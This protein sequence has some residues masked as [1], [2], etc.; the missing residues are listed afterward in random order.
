MIKIF[1]LDETPVEDRHLYQM[2]WSAWRYLEDNY[3]STLRCFSDFDRQDDLSFELEEIMA[4]LAGMSRD[5]WWSAFLS[6][7]KKEKVGVT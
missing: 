2:Y 7:I 3:Y 6:A 5:E 4:G 1:G